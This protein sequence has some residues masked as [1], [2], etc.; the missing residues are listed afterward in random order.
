MKRFAILALLGLLASV[1]SAQVFTG[2]VR[3]Q[4]YKPTG[5][6]SLPNQLTVTTA[7]SDAG[8]YQ[9]INGVWALASGA[10]PVA[11]EYLSAAV[12]DSGTAFASG[13]TRY[14]TNT[15]TIGSVNP[16][17]SALGYVLFT[18]SPT[19]SEYIEFT[20]TLPPYWTGTQVSYSY[21]TAATSGTGVF[22]IQVACLAS[23]SVAGSPTFSAAVLTSVPASTTANGV[24]STGL[25]TAAVPGDGGCVGASPV[26]QLATIR[27]YADSTS[28]VPLYTLGAE[29]ATARSK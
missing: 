9:C 28:N 15:P 20:T 29:F 11:Y 17:Q 21:Y 27:I 8:V 14:S 10:P 13:L 16:T 4:N 5:A 23:E 2:A 24:Q 7:G 25:I 18:A 3:Y 6:C 12:S 26:S 22:D 19:A 1:V